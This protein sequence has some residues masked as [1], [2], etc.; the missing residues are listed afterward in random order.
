MQPD[1][2]EA[3]ESIGMTDEQLPQF[4]ANITEFTQAQLT[5]YV[6]L[7]RSNTMRDA[8]RKMRGKTRTLMRNMDE[9]MGELLDAEQYLRYETYRDLLSAKF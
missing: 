6:R 1:V 4:R 9:Q 8:A 5:A 3:A 2:I 7:S